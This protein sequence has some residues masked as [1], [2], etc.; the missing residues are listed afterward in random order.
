MDNIDGEKLWKAYKDA[1]VK[2]MGAQETSSDELETMGKACMGNFFQGV[3][4]RGE[5]QPR[6]KKR[7]FIIV[8]TM[9]APPGEHWVGIYRE[10]GHPDLVYDSFGRGTMKFAGRP[11]DKDVEQ[12]KS[13]DWC[14]QGCIAFGL[15]AQM[16]GQGAQVV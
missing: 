3:Y 6:N 10:A 14:G 7:D 4:A 5:E 15:V 8:N 16:L 9:S 1:I 12:K 2:E 13:E 11:T